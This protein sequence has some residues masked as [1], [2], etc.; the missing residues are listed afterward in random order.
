MASPNPH[1]EVA[2]SP[3]AGEGQGDMSPAIDAMEVLSPRGRGSGW[4]GDKTALG[5]WL[6]ADSKI[7]STFYVQCLKKDTLYWSLDTGKDCV[8]RKPS[9]L[10]PLVSRYLFL[11][12][13]LTSI[14]HRASSIEKG[15]P[16]RL[17]S[18]RDA[19]IYPLPLRDP[20]ISPLPL[21]ERVRVRG[22]KRAHGW[23][24]TKRREM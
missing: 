13:Q 7:R 5:W 15:S 23:Q 4:G 3:P 21:R 20:T 19:T 12:L 18:L 8:R 14:R 22:N 1:I 17:H 6:I 9:G 10:C 16:R 2:S 11:E 24:R